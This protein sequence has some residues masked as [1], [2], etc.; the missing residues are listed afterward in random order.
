MLPARSPAPPPPNQEEDLT[1]QNRGRS[2]RAF[3][4]CGVSDRRGVTHARE[5]ASW[6]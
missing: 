1:T 3:P 5:V 2:S 6:M 4:Q